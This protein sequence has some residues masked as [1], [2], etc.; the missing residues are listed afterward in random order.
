L[1]IWLR[2][3]EVI[4]QSRCLSGVNDTAG[5]TPAVSLIPL[6]PQQRCQFRL[7]EQALVS[8]TKFKSKE[9][10]FKKRKK[11]TLLIF[12]LNIA[13]VSGVKGKRLL[14]FVQYFVY[15]GGNLKYKFQKL[16]AV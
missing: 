14:K 5:A 15:L 13:W 11:Q 3:R 7:N 10:M 8:F 16:F 4:R 1:H 9:V 6:V 12:F 2:I